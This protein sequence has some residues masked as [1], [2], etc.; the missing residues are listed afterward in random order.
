MS[1]PGTPTY[2][3]LRIFLTVVEVG[4]FAAAGRKLHRA[5]SAI[6][7]GVANL[8][9]QLGLTLFAREGTRRPELTPSGRSVLAEARA[10]AHSMDGL[11]AK[12]KGLH[13]GLEPEVTVVVDVMWPS[14]WLGPVLNAFAR[15][16]PAVSLRLYVESL[17][18]VAAMV[19][20]RRAAFGISGPLSMT[21][22]GLEHL[23]MGSIPM[24]PVAAPSHPLA[25]EQVKPGASRDHIQLVLTDRS[26]LSAG[27]DFGVGSDRT[28]RLGDLGAKHQLLREGIG[29][30]GMPEHLVEADLAAGTLVRLDLPD[31]DAVSYT[32]DGIYRIDT[33]PGPTASWLIRRFV[34]YVAGL[35]REELASA[36][37]RAAAAL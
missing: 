2:D 20:E 6:T 14:A 5:T 27:R 19:T 1:T 25:Q 9:A 23:V 17:G 8:E 10:I 4:S 29:W 35:P 36:S 33:P 22:P 15:A 31:R 26:K 3:Q 28:W 18:S 32:F 12:V 30:G 24:I 37:Q 16:F 21:V 34:E 13:Q 7:Y 11:R